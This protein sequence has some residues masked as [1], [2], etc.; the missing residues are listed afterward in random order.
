MSKLLP[1][2]TLDSGP[3]PRHSI[4]WLHGL[5]ASG[6]D[7]VPVAQA[8]DLPQA[9]RFIFPHAP[10][11][12]VTINGGYVMPAWYDIAGSEIDAKQDAAGI[13]ASRREIEKLIAREVARGI[14]PARIFLAGF[15]QGGAVALHSGLHARENLGGILA[16]STYLPLADATR[17]TD[18]STARDTP[19]FMICRWQTPPA[20]PISAPRG[21]RRSSWRTARW[22]RLFPIRWA[23]S[24]L[25]S[26]N[27]SDARSSGTN[28][29]YSTPCAPRK[30]ATSAGGW[31]DRSPST[32]SR[33]C[34]LAR[35]V[36]DSKPAFHPCASVTSRGGRVFNIIL[37]CCHPAPSC[38]IA[39]DRSP[40]PALPAPAATA[41]I[42]CLPPAS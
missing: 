32:D 13:A 19:V 22:I 4:I 2:I 11:R 40:R 41:D 28:T 29:R 38:G 15:S 34:G 26:C 36:A 42:P 8:L 7:F 37:R 25:P 21:T 17:A 30:S 3:D 20:P 9:M 18:I 14:V 1:H 24:P 33:H 10:Q 23:S 6:E 31:H 35:P 16:L 12:P 39:P 5:G 27:G